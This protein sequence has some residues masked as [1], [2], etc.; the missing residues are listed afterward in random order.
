[1][2]LLVILAMLSFALRA[3]A[4]PRVLVFKSYHDNLTSLLDEYRIQY[5]VKRASVVAGD[6]SLS[7]FDAVFIPCGVEQPIE[8]SIQV[9][10]HGQRIQGVALKD[11]YEGID[12]KQLNALLQDFVK[13][14][15]RLYAA[16]YSYRFVEALGCSLSFFNNFPH[17]GTSGRIHS[18]LNDD[19]ASFVMR[20]DM[21]LTVN[22]NGWVALQRANA[23]IL[24]KGYF[25]T[26]GG[27][28]EGPVAFFKKY[29]NGVVYY[30]AYHTGEDSLYIRYFIFRTAYGMLVDELLQKAWYWGQSI[31]LSVVDTFKG[32]EYARSYT[33]TLPQGAITV[34]LPTTYPVQVDIF[35]N[36]KLLGS[37]DSGFI[38][39]I[40]LYNPATQD[41]TVY[42]Y[43][44]NRAAYKPF[45]LVIA[46]GRRI[47]P[48]MPV[49]R[50]SMGAIAVIMLLGF[51]WK[52]IN[53]RKFAGKRRY[54][55][56]DGHFIHRQK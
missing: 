28:R 31:V 44:S 16:G 11:D 41:A 47:L 32:D 5:I 21:Q 38:T 18:F 22:Y 36:K 46:Q 25:P 2:R 54:W 12:Y 4:A 13:S 14:G 39:E 34:Y 23:S 8:A 45:A 7:G 3:E 55:F 10:A 40:S 33:C 29:G 53:P 19:F 1:M 48:Y 24:A 37:W 27:E 42:V 30:S 43:Q 49:V 17:Y 51:T 15:G 52:R 20:D 6:S 9:M 26:V 56:R 35:A 50:L